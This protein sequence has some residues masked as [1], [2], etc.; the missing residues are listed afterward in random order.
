M[1]NSTTT[2]VVF[3][4]SLDNIYAR[5]ATE[6]SYM[7]EKM[8]SLSMKVGYAGVSVQGKGVSQKKYVWNE[9][10]KDGFL[11]IAPKSNYHFEVEEDAIKFVSIVSM[12]HA[13]LG[14]NVRAGKRQKYVVASW[15][16][17]MRMYQDFG[18][19]ST[20]AWNSAMEAETAKKDKEREQ[21]QI[22]RAAKKKQ[23]EKEVNTIKQSYG[24]N[25]DNYYNQNQHQ[26]QSN[27]SN[28]NYN[29]YLKYANNPDALYEDL[30]Y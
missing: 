28:S 19:A 30:K 15:D 23:F 21:R 13:L 22:N 26:Q 18:T 5:V 8:N 3:N 1:G 14:E 17:Y 27:G 4:G 9:F 20:A 25:N 7:V 6:R 16:G 10:I 11:K 29:Y 2:F 24:S 12:E